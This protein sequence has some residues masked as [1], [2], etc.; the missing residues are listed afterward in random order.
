MAE[1]LTLSKDLVTRQA[2]INIASDR[3]TVFNYLSA[4]ESL[5]H[6]L[7][8]YGPIH[9]VV[10]HETHKGPWSM[11]GACRTLY[12]DNGDTLREEMI[13]YHPHDSFSYHI[14]DFSGTVKNLA[15]MAIGEFSFSSEGSQT[16]VVWTYT[17][18]A[19]NAFTAV[20]V[21]LFMDLFFKKYMQQ[22][23]LIAKANIENS[24]ADKGDL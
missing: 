9:A 8:K 14:S 10:K 21:S 5:T 20:I 2:S 18:Q 4:E 19:K 15:S 13:S 24:P 23:L 12:F 6:F 22:N 16:N 3:E 11:P 17:F 1:T 7:K